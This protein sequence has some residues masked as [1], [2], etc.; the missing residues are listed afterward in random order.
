PFCFFAALR[1]KRSWR[2]AAVQP[3]SKRHLQN[4]NRLT[5]PRN[6][7]WHGLRIPRSSASR[8]LCHRS[9]VLTNERGTPPDRRGGAGAEVEGCDGHR[10]HRQPETCEHAAP[11]CASGR[12]SV[13][14]P[15]TGNHVVGGCGGRTRTG[16]GLRSRSWKNLADRVRHVSQSSR[17]LRPGR[18]PQGRNAI[19]QVGGEAPVGRDAAVAMVRAAT[20]HSAGSGRRLAVVNAAANSLAVVDSKARPGRVGIA[21]SF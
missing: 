9:A 17:A 1:A 16:P 8:E 11:G 19:A 13:G 10:L 21:G 14:P 6:A 3:I 15:K 4:S 20:T 5:R 7:L 2:L 18:S 12:G